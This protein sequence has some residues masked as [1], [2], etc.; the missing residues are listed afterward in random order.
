MTATE[1]KRLY[2]GATTCD[3]TPAWRDTCPELLAMLRACYESDPDEQT[4]FLALA[5][6]LGER[7]DPREAW[8]RTAVRVWEGAARLPRKF[9]P[10]AARWS[11]ET[12]KAALA[13]VCETT[14]GWRLAGLWGAALAWHI[15]SGDGT[16]ERMGRTWVDERVR[17]VNRCLWFWGME[18]LETNSVG[19]AAW[20]QAYAAWRQAYAAGRQADAAGSQ[21]YAAWRQADAA[22]SQ[23]DAAWRQA[24]AAGRQA[25]AAGSQADAAGRQADAAW[26][27]A[28]AWRFARALWLKVCAPELKKLRTEQ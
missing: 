3:L 10:N 25:Y 14:E 28:D 6:L 22:G 5:D 12:C 26:R 1:P 23:A 15:P 9:T 17:V 24:Y 20:S 19:S 7:S 16:G 18:F 2:Q 8:V 13:P 27:Q 4:P 11:H 21:A